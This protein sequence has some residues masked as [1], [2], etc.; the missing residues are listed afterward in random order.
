M[1][2]STGVLALIPKQIQ[3]PDVYLNA[4]QDF[5]DLHRRMEPLD[6]DRI[7]WFELF[8][9]T[10]RGWMPALVYD[11]EER[12]PLADTDDVLRVML[13]YKF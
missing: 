4:E 7:V 8:R 1:D 13:E 11:E 12:G 6:T 10:R 3:I 9:R 5:I 2:R